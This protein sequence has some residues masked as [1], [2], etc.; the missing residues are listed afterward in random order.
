MWSNHLVNGKPYANWG[1]LITTTTN[2]LI[3][4]IK[5][6]NHLF[7]EGDIKCHNAMKG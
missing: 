7:F 6:N 2:D 3:Q 5:K 4:V 1:Y